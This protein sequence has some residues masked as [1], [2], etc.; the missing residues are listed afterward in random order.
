MSKEIRDLWNCG[1]DGQGK[2]P[3]GNKYHRLHFLNSKYATNW[4]VLSSWRSTEKGCVLFELCVRLTVSWNIYRV[5]LD[6]FPRNLI[7]EMYNSKGPVIRDITFR[8]IVDKYSW[9]RM[10]KASVFVYRKDLKKLINMAD[11]ES[12]SATSATST[13][14]CYCH[15]P[16]WLL[17]IKGKIKINSPNFAML[18]KDCENTVDRHYKPSGNTLRA[19]IKSSQKK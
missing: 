14:N 11:I 10:V 12:C 2:A 9:T 17:K 7:Q 19:I 15:K 13:L 16:S 8:L 1:L 5:M 4:L 3:I 6:C 18:S